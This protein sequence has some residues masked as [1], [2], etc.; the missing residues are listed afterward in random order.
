MPS[1]TVLTINDLALRWRVDRKSLYGMI[2]RGEL[3]VMRIG[4]LIR[5]A[6]A[7]VEQLEQAGAV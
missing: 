5:V 1:Q 3:P 2:D 7:V 4:R 6:L